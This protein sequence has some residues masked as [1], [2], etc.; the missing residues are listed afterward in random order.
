MERAP[1]II[2]CAREPALEPILDFTYSDTWYPLSDG[3]GFS[4]VIKNENAPL[5]TWGDKDSWRI[6]SGENG[7]QRGE[8]EQTN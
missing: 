3:L 1:E 2:E 7:S 5:N 6:S 8:T 4:L